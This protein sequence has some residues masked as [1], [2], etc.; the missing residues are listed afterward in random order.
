MATREELR[1]SG[2]RAYELGRLRMASR[3]GWVLVPMA[4]VCALTTR[5]DEVCACLGVL[6]F[7]LSAYLR[8]RDRRGQS[9]VA[10]GLTAGAVPLLAGVLTT[11]LVPACAELST[12]WQ[13]AAAC[14]SVGVPSG[15]WL[16]RRAA[17]RQFDFTAVLLSAGVASLVASLGWAGLGVVGLLGPCSACLSAAGERFGSPVRHDFGAQQP[18]ADRAQWGRCFGPIASRRVA[19]FRSSCSGPFA[20]STQQHSAGPSTAQRTVTGVVPAHSKSK[21][22]SPDCLRRHALSYRWRCSWWA[23]LV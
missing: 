13:C 21:V 11:Q 12:P 14:L 15:L 19:H 22:S 6:L 9:V 16:G 5:A 20:S 8:W 10:I 17:R 7:A 18:L 4:L 2:Q 23:R 3:I 1:R